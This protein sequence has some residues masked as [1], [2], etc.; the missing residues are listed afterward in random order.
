[1][2]SFIGTNNHIVKVE[3]VIFPIYSIKIYNKGEERIAPFITEHAITSYY[4]F[5]FTKNFGEILKKVSKQ[6]GIKFYD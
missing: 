4:T 6:T 3:T 2:K 5:L 1:M